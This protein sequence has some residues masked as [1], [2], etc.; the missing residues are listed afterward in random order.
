MSPV[1]ARAAADA[2]VK[3][4]SGESISNGIWTLVGLAVAGTLTA[5]GIWLKNRPAGKLADAEA[6]KVELDGDEK[7]RNE[8][9]RDIEKLKANKEETGRRLT[10]AETKIAAQE[11]QI[12][13]LRF[14]VALVNS[15]LERV[16]PGNAIAK[17]V[18]LIMDDM[19][20]LA[21]NSHTQD[22]AEIVDSV[23]KLCVVK[24]VGE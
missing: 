24:G 13:Q 4:T 23:S 20:T 16:S 14:L 18:R 10:L 19:Q 3:T 2:V 5:L 6:R 8:M 1:V 9:W 21:S 15:E 22:V 7:L 12:G 11:S 17:Q